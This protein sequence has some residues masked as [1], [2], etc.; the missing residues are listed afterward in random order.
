MEAEFIKEH[1]GSMK[2]VGVKRISAVK[3]L[4]TR[5]RADLEEHEDHQEMSLWAAVP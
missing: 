1:T 4:L 5:I 2:A 3:L